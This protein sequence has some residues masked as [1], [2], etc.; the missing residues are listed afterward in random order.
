LVNVIEPAEASGKGQSEAVEQ[1]RLCFIGLGHATQGYL[2]LWAA[3]LG[4]GAEGQVPALDPCQILN[5]CP[6]GIAQAGMVH[7][8][9]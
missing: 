7:P 6:R 2:P 9:A 4:A 5:Q 3:A 1:H 8:A